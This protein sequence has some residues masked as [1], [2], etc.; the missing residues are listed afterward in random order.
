MAAGYPKNTGFFLLLL[1]DSRYLCLTPTL[2]HLTVSYLVSLF[3]FL[4]LKAEDG[5]GE[6][7]D[8]LFD[9]NA[10]TENVSFAFSY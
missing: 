3:M 7:I 2:C 5:A 8:I 4:N 6:L 10:E 1:M 9:S